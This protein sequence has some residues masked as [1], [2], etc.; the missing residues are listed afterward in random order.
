MRSHYHGKNS[1]SRKTSCE[2]QSNSHDQCAGASF[3]HA[4]KAGPSASSRKR[5]AFFRTRNDGKVTQNQ[6][7]VD[8]VTL[9]IEER[10]AKGS[11]V[12][13]RFKCLIG[14]YGS[15]T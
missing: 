11:A 3:A 4:R 2:Q 5:S 10:S 12:D 14:T 8:A 1:F 7:A 15:L 9:L 13:A 6:L